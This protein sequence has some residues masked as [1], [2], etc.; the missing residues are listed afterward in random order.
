MT[1]LQYVEC[2][3]QEF[4]VCFECGNF[5]YMNSSAECDCG[6]HD[7]DINP[8]SVLNQIDEVK[9]VLIDLSDDHDMRLEDI[10]LYGGI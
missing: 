3:P 10:D 2:N 5:A 6:S 1:N 7:W 4:K 9:Q 8:K